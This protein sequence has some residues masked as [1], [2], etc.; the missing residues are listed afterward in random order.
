MGLDASEFYE[1]IPSFIGAS[2]RLECLVKSK[3]AFLFKDFA[4][5]PSKVT[6]T[7]KAIKKQFSNHKIMICL[8][9]HTYSSLDSE[10]IEQYAYSLDQADEVIVFYDPEALKIKKQAPITPES[11]KQAFRSTSINIFNNKDSLLNFLLKKKYENKVLVMMSSGSFGDL[12][13][14]TLKS[15][16]SEF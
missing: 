8:E 6:A 10:F 11:V 5:A 7:S 2:K 4:H 16:V 9:L 15:R 3:T 12:D 13:L 1:A 14:E